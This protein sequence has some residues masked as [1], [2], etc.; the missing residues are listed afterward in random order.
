MEDI[1]YCYSQRVKIFLHENGY[2]NIGVGTVDSGK[3][4]WKFKRGAELDELLKKYKK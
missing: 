4:Y 2:Y 1:F 3:K